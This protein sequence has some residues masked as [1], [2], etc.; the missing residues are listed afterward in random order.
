MGFQTLPQSVTHRSLTRCNKC[1]IL[2]L[3]NKWL[4]PRPA[5]QRMLCAGIYC[6]FAFALTVQG[7]TL[8]LCPQG[9]IGVEAACLPSDCC[10]EG[11]GESECSDGHL[12]HEMSARADTHACHACFDIAVPESGIDGSALGA[13]EFRAS[14]EKPLDGIALARHA[15]GRSPGVPD[16]GVTSFSPALTASAMP[17][18]ESMPL[19]LQL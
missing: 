1:D 10:G 15:M 4:K 16:T 5:L 12:G 11:S 19:I 3:M 18:S 13:A 2:Y 8:C 7:F 17:A 9:R 14:K 6:T